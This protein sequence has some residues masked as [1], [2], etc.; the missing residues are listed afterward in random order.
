ME[1]AKP[2]LEG[3]YFASDSYEAANGVDGLVIL[4]EWNQFRHLDLSRLRAAM[5]RP[6]IVDLRNIYEPA[7]M[8]QAGFHY[9]SIGR[10]AA[11]PAHV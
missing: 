8:A 9:V 2:E 6:L 11:A 1:P 5:R 3:A 7:K 4:T 10:A